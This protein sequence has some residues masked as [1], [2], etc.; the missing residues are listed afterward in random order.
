MTNWSTF[1]KKIAVAA[2][3]EKVYQAWSTQSGI[4]S[5]FLRRAIYTTKDGNKRKPYDS[6]AA[7]DTY[8]WHW[9]GFPDSVKESH[10]IVAAN[11]K[12]EIKFYFTT[13]CLVTVSLNSFK[14]Q[15]IVSLTQENIPEDN[16]PKTN[17]LVGCGE[18]WTFYLANLKS[19]LEGGIDLRNKD[20][21]IMGVI[22]S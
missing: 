16:N 20:E 14:N 9:H 12:D 17:L 6:I 22:N 21:Q 7:G 19:I 2:P 5:W 11:G 10:E 4:E 1:T 8:V 3:L 15:T 13:K 18:G